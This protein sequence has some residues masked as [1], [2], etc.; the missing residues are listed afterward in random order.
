MT[1]PQTQD[2]PPDAASGQRGAVVIAGGSGLIGRRLSAV[3]AGAGYDVVI[4][5]RSA[6]RPAVGP[7]RFAQWRGAE[8]SSDE[9]WPELLEGAQAVVNLC[10]E[11]IGGPRWTPARKSRLIESRVGPTEA[12][13]SAI[14]AADSPP[15]VFLQVSGV[16]YYGTGN[17]P[18]TE[19]S[20]RGDDFLADLAVR[21]EAPVKSLRTDVRP[22]IARLGVVLAV[23]GGALTQMLMPFRLFVGGPIASGN[24]W[25][26]WIHLHDAGSALEMLLEQPDCRG[27]YNLT[28]PNPIRN[29]D[30]AK[31]AGHA[32]KRPSWMFTPRILLKGLLGEQ[33]TLV[34]DG[35]QALP[36]RL[37]KANFRFSY[38]TI[39]SAL[40]A[41]L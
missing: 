22:V 24:Q 38:P 23:T 9:T 19:S 37:E 13:V 36:E 11:S 7:I 33:A 10:G 41:L 32:L 4:L 17:R 2:D 1:D 15:A 31:A 6:P 40:E 34:C 16:G 5:T 28:A 3:L 27:V 30:F 35:Q 39:E 20:G 21:W 12:L 25:L 14:N 8:A 29:A 26:S 18:V